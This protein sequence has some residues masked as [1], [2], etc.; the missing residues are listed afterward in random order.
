MHPIVLQHKMALKLVMLDCQWLSVSLWKWAVDGCFFC[1]FLEM[2]EVF[3]LFPHMKLECAYTLLFIYVFFW[4]EPLALEFEKK[5]GTVCVVVLC[6]SVHCVHQEIC[7]S[8]H[9][10][11]QEMVAYSCGLNCIQCYN[12]HDVCISI[13]MSSCVLYT[14]LNRILIPL[15]CLFTVAL[16]PK[17]CVKLKPCVVVCD[18]TVI[19]SFLCGIV[20][21]CQPVPHQS[22]PLCRSRYSIQSKEGASWF[23]RDSSLNCQ[24]GQSHFCEKCF[25]PQYY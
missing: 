24:V 21:V 2:V 19:N 25:L 15:R 22:C 11:H 13:E 5:K 6:Y 23:L 1:T 8:V 10:V 7:Y 16:L 12:L 18:R 20:Q 17:G 9:C 4:I 14:L 3:N